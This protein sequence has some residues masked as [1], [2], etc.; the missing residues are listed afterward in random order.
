MTYSTLSHLSPS[1]TR[2]GF[3][4]NTY[5]RCSHMAAQTHLKELQVI[6]N[7][8]LR[9]ILNAPRYIPRK[10]I[11]ADLK[12]S[13]LNARIRELASL[14]FQNVPTHS[15]TTIAQA[16]IITPGLHK[17]AAASASLQDLF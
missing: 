8:T 11:H 4:S 12:I 2:G 16:A 10:Y 5:N 17:H 15:N 6:Q 3:F 14:F 1:K 7:I 13:P 9:M